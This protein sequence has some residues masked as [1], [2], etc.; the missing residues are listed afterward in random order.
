MM[1]AGSGEDPPYVVHALGEFLLLNVRRQA[2]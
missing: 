1:V 2:D